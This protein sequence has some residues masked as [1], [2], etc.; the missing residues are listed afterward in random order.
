MKPAQQHP[1]VEKSAWQRTLST[2]LFCSSASQSKS[3]RTGRRSAYNQRQLSG[4]PQPEVEAEDTA[5][6]CIRWKDGCD[7]ERR[8][9]SNFDRSVGIHH[10]ARAQHMFVCRKALVAGVGFLFG[11]ERAP[12]ATMMRD[13]PS[14]T[15]QGPTQKAATAHPRE[16]VQ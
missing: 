13:V 8:G 6:C 5:E 14:P 15:P 2:H 7:N 3:R 9:G 1:C 11:E 4:V 12:T 10:N 16:W